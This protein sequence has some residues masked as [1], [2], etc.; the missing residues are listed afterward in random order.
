MVDWRV[1]CEDVLG[2]D[3]LTYFI[4]ASVPRND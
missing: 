4:Y 1:Y 2:L 3:E